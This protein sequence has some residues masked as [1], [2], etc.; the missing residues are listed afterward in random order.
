MEERLSLLVL[1]RLEQQ[2]QRDPLR[3][4]PIPVPLLTAEQHAHFAA[5]LHQQVSGSFSQLFALRLSFLFTKLVS[6]SYACADS[7][8]RLT[9]AVELADCI[10]A[11]G[12]EFDF[13]TVIICKCLNGGRSKF[14]KFCSFPVVENMFSCPSTTHTH[15]HIWSER[16]REMYVVSGVDTFY[17][18]AFLPFSV[19]IMY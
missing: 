3:D 13:Q 10:A 12:G 19:L 18:F 9:P 2:Q 14:F 4:F 17:F 16:E 7:C 6:R 1:R 8:R 5:V 15:T 11:V